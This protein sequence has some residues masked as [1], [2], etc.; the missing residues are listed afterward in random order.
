MFDRKI[1]SLIEI[2][3]RL[4]LDKDY[5]HVV[6]AEHGFYQQMA[7]EDYLKLIFQAKM[8]KSLCLENPLTFNEKLQWLKLYDRRIEYTTMVDKY[9][10]REYIIQKIGAKY[11]IPLV[12]VW[13]TPD[14]IDFAQ[15]PMQFVL[16]CNHNS[17]LGMCICRDKN[18]LDWVQVKRR[19][20]KGLKEDYYQK[21][22][23]W[24][25]QGVKRK[26]IA[27][28]YLEDDRQT[29]GIIDYKIHNF[30]GVPK[31]ILVCKNRFQQDG[32]TEDFFD[33]DWKHLNVARKKYQNALEYPEKP[34]KLDEMLKLSQILSEDIPFLRT[35]FYEVEGK[36]Y[37]GEL[38]FFPSSGLEGFIPQEWDEQLGRWLRL[39]DFDGI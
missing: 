4:V 5:R 28:E 34:E 2:G 11:L 23:E 18:K 37:F 19:L 13:N 30:N 21:Y 3:Q 20:S 7:D 32:M 36:I 14:E 38:T 39:P 15:L 24:P 12:G 9:Q 27:E 25:Y 29:E 10:V 8:K 26:I 17:G 33:V 22:R 1:T 35:D 16:K 6:L 31:M